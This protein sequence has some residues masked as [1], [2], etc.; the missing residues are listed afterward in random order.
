MTLINL[1]FQIEFASFKEKNKIAI[2]LYEN[3]FLF[4]IIM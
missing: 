2:D 4:K 3:L 1:L